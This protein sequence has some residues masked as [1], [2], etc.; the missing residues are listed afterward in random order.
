MLGGDWK[1][2]TPNLSNALFPPALNKKFKFLQVESLAE[3]TLQ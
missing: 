2:F 1:G 3:S